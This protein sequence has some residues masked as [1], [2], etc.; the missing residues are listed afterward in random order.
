M[1]SN[2]R[3]T[4]KTSLKATF[5]FGRKK[6][7]LSANDSINEWSKSSQ[8]KKTEK[9]RFYG[10]TG[11]PGPIFQHSISQK[12]EEICHS[13]VGR[14][15]FGVHMPLFRDGSSTANFYKTSK[16]TNILNAKSANPFCNMAR[17]SLGNESM[18]EMRLGRDMVILILP[19]P[20][21]LIRKEQSCMEPIREME[22]SRFVINSHRWQSS[23]QKR[24]KRGSSESKENNQYVAKVDFNISSSTT[25]PTPLSV[26]SD[27]T[28]K[29]PW[30]ANQ[31]YETQVYQTQKYCGEQKWWLNKLR[32]NKGERVL[33]HASDLVMQSDAAK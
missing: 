27:A 4:L 20:G 2:K 12:Q 24:K 17:R 22:F 29:K 31:P 26:T 18:E 9:K 19:N 30:G 5:S 14:K 16:Y 13:P 33:I 1:Q 32:L 7:T 21:F 23:S 11:P 10:K 6:R 3:A 25:K 28:N 15:D 8:K